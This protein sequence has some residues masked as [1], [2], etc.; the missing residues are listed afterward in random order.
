[1]QPMA[2]Y[3][4]WHLNSNDPPNIES[5]GYRFLA[6]GDSWFSIG[7]LN[8]A[9]N[10]NLLFEMA[11]EKSSC[12]IN[13]ASPGDTLRRMSQ[14]NTDRDFIRLLAGVESRAWDGVLLSAGG[15]DLIDALQ[16]RGPGIPLHLR[17]L[18][19]P[20]EW[21]DPSEGPARYLSDAGWATFCGYLEANLEHLIRL[22]DSGKAVGCPVFM[23]GYAV[24]TPRPAGVIGNIGPW[25]YPA[26][27]AATIPIEIG[28]AS[29]RERVSLNV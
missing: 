15:N 24:P 7:A 2:I 25:L 20:D 4:P 21:G 27:M 3:S 28:R 14:M 10:S 13:C 16:V 26:V 29:C 9:K 17:L 18:R 8:P 11:F 12:A 5:R 23:H 6:E 1:M 19:T 22:R